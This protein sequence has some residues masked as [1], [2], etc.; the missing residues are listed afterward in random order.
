[1]EL[2]LNLA[3]PKSLP[4]PQMPTREPK[5][6]KDERTSREKTEPTVMAFGM[7]AGEYEQASALLLPAATTT[8]ALALTALDSLL[9][10]L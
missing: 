1:M 4:G 2:P 10:S 3:A 8:A 5:L 9:E 7:K 6:E